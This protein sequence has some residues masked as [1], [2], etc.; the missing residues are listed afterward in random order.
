MS[1]ISDLLVKINQSYSKMSKGQKLLANYISDYYDRAAFFTASKLGQTVGVSESTVVRFATFLGYKGF[2][3]FQEALQEM[4]ADKLNDTEQQDM[5]Y[6]RID[7][8]DI[9]SSIL[10][11]DADKI[12]DTLANIDRMA[13]ERAI[14]TLLEARKIY[15]IGVRSCAPLASYLA[16]Q[17]NLI[18]DQVQLISTSNVSEV[19]EQM[20]HIGP[21]DAIIG[22]SFPRY[23]VRTLKAMEFAND[24]NAKVITLTDSVHSPMNLYSSCNLL[25]RTDMASVMESLVAPMSIINALL[26]ALCNRRQDQVAKNLEL[27]EQTWEDYQVYEPDEIDSIDDALKMH[28]PTQE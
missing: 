3:E 21:E 10:T 25:A 18:F 27:L 8:N 9:L 13:F 1:S 17:L 22:I 16:F 26:V 4:V 12:T 7:R 11:S 6:G 5:T 28:Y 24:R 20:L 14:D 15:I 19:F 23:S 2:P